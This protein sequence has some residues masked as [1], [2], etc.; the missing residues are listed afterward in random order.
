MKR[1]RNNNQMCGEHEA[2]INLLIGWM[3]RW[4]KRLWYVLIG[5][6]IMLADKAFDLAARLMN[7]AG[8]AVK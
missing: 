8:A 4:D 7:V 1:A 3:E 2:K 5:I 6:T